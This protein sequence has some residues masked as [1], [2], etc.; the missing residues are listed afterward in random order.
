MNR[1]Y[2][3]QRTDDGHREKYEEQD[4]VGEDAKTERINERR[5]GNLQIDYQI[6]GV[7]FVLFEHE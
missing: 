1:G 2:G 6:R 5:L 4:K 7:V 3:R